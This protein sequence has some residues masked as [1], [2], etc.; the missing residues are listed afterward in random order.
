MNSP[1]V[2]HADAEKLQLHPPAPVV[3]LVAVCTSHGQA[4]LQ[5]I[6]YPKLLRTGMY[7]MNVG[8]VV[9]ECFLTGT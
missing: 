5:P 4:A 3:V 2:R 9:G 1:H 6:L 7:R 8:V